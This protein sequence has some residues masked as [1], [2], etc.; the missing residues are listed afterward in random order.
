MK[1]TPLQ[2]YQK[3]LREACAKQTT[4][5]WFS[6]YINKSRGLGNTNALIAG[7]KQS[8]ATL[9]THN[10]DFAEA[11]AEN[12]RIKTTHIND[13]M[14]AQIPTKSVVD[15]FAIYQLVQDNQRLVALAEQLL[16]L[17]AQKRIE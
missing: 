6:R 5:D 3:D 11:I 7:C 4:A 16:S 9:I 8:A 15:N 17:M 1:Y 10:H 14:F 12:H 2:K 13:K